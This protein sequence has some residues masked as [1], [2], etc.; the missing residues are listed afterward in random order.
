MALKRITVTGVLICV[1]LYALFHKDV[2]T[3]LEQIVGV[4]TSSNNVTGSVSINLHNDYSFECDISDQAS[5]LTLHYKGRWD[6][7]G[8]SINR[9]TTIP[10]DAIF[11]AMTDDNQ[12]IFNHFVVEIDEHSLKLQNIKGDSALL[13]KR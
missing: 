11:T 1:G 2:K 8:T 6:M 3:P 12:Q 4:W 10:V 7:N 9:K 5:N 13:F